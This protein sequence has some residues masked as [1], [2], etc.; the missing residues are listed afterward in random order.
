VF[1]YRHR[2]HAGNHADVM[3]HV[4]LARL[5]VSLARKDTP[6]CYVDTHAGVGCYALDHPWSSKNAEHADGVA[7]VWQRAD[8]PAL[9]EP[10]LGVV[11]GLNPDGRLQVCPGSPEIV[12]QLRRPT[13]RMV[14]SEI[15]VE[16][17]E[18]LRDLM[19]GER[20]LSVLCQ[21]GYQTLRSALPPAERRGLV[22]I[23]SSF[24][25][26][27]E[28]ARLVQA[29]VEA[30]RR[31]ATGI[32]VIWYPLMDPSA[33]RRFERSVRDSGIRRILQA[34]LSVHPADWS[35]SLRGSGLLVVNPPWGFEDEARQVLGWLA[36]VL[37]QTEGSSRVHWLVPE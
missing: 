17:H 33:M 19:A 7:R 22:L 4:L 6:W 27:G 24:D 12:R 18:A 28:F 25:R 31:F 1:A 26:A 35:G 37:A 32:F 20:R 13:D 21:D 9:L 34:E 30:H 3:K 8:A 36:P 10:W 5:L 23:D 29:L 14:L 16:D 2:F 11:R 15:N